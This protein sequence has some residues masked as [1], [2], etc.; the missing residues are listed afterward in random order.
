MVSENKGRLSG[1]ELASCFI[2]EK[3]G[4]LLMAVAV[5]EYDE[6]SGGEASDLRRMFDQGR[7]TV[8]LAAVEVAGAGPSVSATKRPSKPKPKPKPKPPSKPYVPEPV[9]PPPAPPPPPPPGV[10]TEST[11]PGIGTEPPGIGTNS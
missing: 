6:A 8:P 9:S 11:P 5:A 3:D 7:R 4:R 10:G 1:S 2:I